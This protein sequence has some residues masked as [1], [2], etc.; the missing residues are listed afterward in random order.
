MA[1]K[2]AKKAGARGKAAKRPAAKKT[3]KSKSCGKKAACSEKKTTPAKSSAGSTRRMQVGRKIVEM[4]TWRRIGRLADDAL[5]AL[6]EDKIKQARQIINSVRAV[7][8]SADR[9]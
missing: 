6:D 2:K 5:V 7:A 8:M 1:K 9:A 4:R 3:A